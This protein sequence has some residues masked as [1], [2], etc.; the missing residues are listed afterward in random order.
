[1]QTGFLAQSKHSIGLRQTII[2]AD[3]AKTPAVGDYVPS[4]GDFRQQFLLIQFLQLLDPP[5][6]IRS[7]IVSSMPIIKA[8]VMTNSPYLSLILS[9]ASATA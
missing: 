3:N 4:E 7:M 1:M 6:A 5:K 8:G 9:I 2:C